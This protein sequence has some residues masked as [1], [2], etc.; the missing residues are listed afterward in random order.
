MVDKILVLAGEQDKLEAAVADLAAQLAPRADAERAAQREAESA[1]KQQAEQE[2]LRC[3]CP[4]P[5]FPR[6]S[7]PHS[8]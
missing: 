5:P 2:R 4:P 8:S 1:A 7:S 6:M 3:M